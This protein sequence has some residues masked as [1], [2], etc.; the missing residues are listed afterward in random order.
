MKITKSQ[1][2]VL[3]SYRCERLSENSDNFLLISDFY[4]SKNSSLVDTFQ[5][6]AYSDDENNRLAYYVVKDK[7]DHIMLF[8]SLKCGLLY[9]EF[10]EGDRLKEIKA[11]YDRIFSISKDPSLSLDDKKV[12]ASILERVRSKKDIKQEDVARVLHLSDTNNELSQIFAKNLKNVGKTFPGVEIVHICANDA[13][14]SSWDE[15]GLPQ[16]MATV[17]FWWFV[18]PKVL[19][20]M[21]IAGCEYLFLFAADLTDDETLI[22]Y[23][24][25]NM[26]FELADE[27]CAAIPM[28]DFTCQFMSQKTSDLLQKQKA[29][30]ENFS[31][32]DE[33]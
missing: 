2:A 27:H 31:P 33:F 3:D 26:G 18:V 9:D 7:D 16:K 6:E 12:V 8:F 10:L 5:G 22:S 20:L 1:L 28:Y 15:N 29:F 32:E 13:Y 17:F 14:R 4:N 30:F 23:Y 24:V 19:D 25:E 11:C 21:K